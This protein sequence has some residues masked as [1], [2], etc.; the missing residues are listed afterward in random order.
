MCGAQWSRLYMPGAGEGAFQKAASLPTGV[1]ILDLVHAVACAGGQGGGA[2]GRAT[3]DA[4]G[5]PDRTTIWA[6]VGM[7]RLDAAPSTPPRSTT[8]ERERPLSGCSNQQPPDEARAL[9]MP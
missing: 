6:M 3:L 7:S 9:R 8:D 4:A 2:G 1:L 5:T